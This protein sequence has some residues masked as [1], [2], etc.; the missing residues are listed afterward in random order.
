MWHS[1]Y[2]QETGAPT[3]AGTNETHIENMLFQNFAGTVDE[4][5]FL[6]SRS[7][8]ISKPS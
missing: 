2:D 1:Y 3:G 4:Y 7:N 6:T 5:V 8:P